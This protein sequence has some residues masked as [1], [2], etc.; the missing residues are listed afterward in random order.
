MFLSTRDLDYFYKFIVG[1]SKKN[2]EKLLNKKLS[3]LIFKSKNYPSL[4]FI[5]FFIFLFFSG[6][7]FSKHRVLIYYKNIEVGRFVLAQTF[8]KFESYIDKKFFYFTYFKNFIRA[9]SIIKACENYYKNYSIKG[10]YIDHCGYINGVIFSFFSNKKIPI[11]TNSY[12]HSILCVDY[13][14]KINPKFKKYEN[15]IK[16]SKKINLN[17]KQKLLSKKCISNLTKKKNFIPW[18]GNAKFKKIHKINYKKFD[19]VIYAHSFTDGQLCYGYDG[20]ENT[21]DWLI[22]TIDKLV[23]NN[24]KILVKSHPNFFNKSLTANS[25]WDRKIFMVIKKQ[26]KNNKNIYFLDAPIHNYELLKKLHHK[27]I[28]ITKHGSVLLEG[29]F[30][31]FKSICSKSNFIDTNFKVSNTWK[32]VFEYNKLL[33]MNFEDLHYSNKNDLFKLIYTLFNIYASPYN[34][35]FYF[36]MISKSVSLNSKQFNR[37]FPMGGRSKLPKSRKKRLDS[38]FKNKF[39]SIAEKLADKIWMVK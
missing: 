3:L 2:C 18:L 36:K 6:K 32:N 30:T 13:R 20:F 37:L 31:N 23:N 1:A 4:N 17:K 8:W 19:Y 38:L 12:P 35:N 29:S 27:C 26:Y 28:L 7:L 25:E 34:S 11:Y 24:K 21:L 15:A 14:K 22:F 9:G 39:E 33:S 5:L 10:V 16:I